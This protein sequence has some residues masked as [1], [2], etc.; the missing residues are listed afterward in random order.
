[1]DTAPDSLHTLIVS[2]DV[3]IRATEQLETIPEVDVVCYGLWLGPEIAKNHGVF[4]SRRDYPDR[5]ECML[6]KPKIEQLGQ[7]TKR[8]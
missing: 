4:V 2:G 6:Q 5:L 8:H 1:M 3:L 7:L